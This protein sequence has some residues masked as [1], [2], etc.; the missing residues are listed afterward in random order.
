MLNIVI[1]INICDYSY[2]VKNDQPSISG[3]EKSVCVARSVKSRRFLTNRDVGEWIFLREGCYLKCVVQMQP[4]LLRVSMLGM[5]S[6]MP[7]SFDPHDMARGRGQQQGWWLRLSESWKWDL[8][9]KRRSSE[10]WWMKMR[11]EVHELLCDTQTQCFCSQKAEGRSA[12][13]PLRCTGQVLPESEGWWRPPL[14]SSSPWDLAKA[15]VLAWQL[16]A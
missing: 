10:G 6:N 4:C 8:Q 12:W 7:F 13:A 15:H 11:A 5:V 9:T 14:L 1:I 16:R 3:T 2:I